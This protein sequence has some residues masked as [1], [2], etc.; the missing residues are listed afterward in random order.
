[1]RRVYKSFSYQETL[2]IAKGFAKGL[3]G[4]EIILLE[5]ELGAGKTAFCTGIF[6]GLGCEGYCSS[7]TFAILNIYE[8]R[9]RLAHLD[10]YRLNDVDLDE[11][12]FYDLLDEGAVLAVEWSARAPE[13][14][15]EPHILITIKAEKEKR[16][17]TIEYKKGHADDNICTG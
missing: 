3:V 8:G 10:L 17:I 5:G 12:G 16:H 4:G 14:Y 13:L 7:P 6:E 11:L 1:M 15:I 2:D 9:H